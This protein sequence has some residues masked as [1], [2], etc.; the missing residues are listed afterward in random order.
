M[1]ASLPPV[2]A[3]RHAH[4]P[5]ARLELA[6]EIPTDAWPVRLLLRH[7]P[8][9]DLFL[10]R[11]RVGLG[12]PVGGHRE[13]PVHHDRDGRVRVAR[14]ARGDIDREDGQ[15]TWWQALGG[16]APY[17]LRRRGAR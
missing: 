5:D 1:G 16:I 9:L 17:D 13:A 6:A 4:S 11:S 2:H 7:A 10:P 12:R 8:P 3:R 15:A 14:S